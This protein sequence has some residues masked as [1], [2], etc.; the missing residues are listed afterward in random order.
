VHW[1]T[2]NLDNQYYKTNINIFYF[3]LQPRFP[4]PQT[5]VFPPFALLHAPPHKT[6]QSNVAVGGFVGWG[7]GNLVGAAVVG[8]PV[9]GEGVGEEVVGAGVGGA[10]VGEGVGRG[11]GA[12]VGGGFVGAGVGAGVVGEGVGMSVG[13]GVGTGGR[14]GN[15]VG[16]G[17][18]LTVG[19][20]VAGVHEAS[21]S[22]ILILA[23]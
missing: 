3:L 9:V 18:G 19:G 10:V 11:V 20:G 8:A 21:F 15:L 13:G 14:V 2:N 7:V 1:L 5:H 17:V 6:E 4:P 12:L 23:K 22:E 16:L